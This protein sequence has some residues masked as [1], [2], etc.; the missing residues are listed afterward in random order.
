MHAHTLIHTYTHN[1][2]VQVDII[3]GAPLWSWPHTYIHTYI[4]SYIHTQIHTCAGGYHLWGT[5]MVLA[6]YIHIYTHTYIHTYTHVQADIIFGAPL[7][8]W[9]IEELVNNVVK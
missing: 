7:W 5:A 3:F 4:H 8:S 2:H 9:Q 6:S 1:T